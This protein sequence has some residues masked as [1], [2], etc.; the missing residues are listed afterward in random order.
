MP[1]TPLNALFLNCTLKRSPELSH[2]DALIEASRA[3]MEANGVSVDA[4][5]PVA[6]IGYLLIVPGLLLVS[7]FRLYLKDPLAQLV[8]AVG[9]SLI[10]VMVLG[11]VLSG[12]PASIIEQPL[13]AEVFVPVSLAITGGLALLFILAL[14]ILGTAQQEAS[15]IH[16]LA[17]PRTIG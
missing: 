12:I 1:D 2:T 11:L 7:I 16:Q 10:Y 13:S 5:R 14:V 9:L 8:T 17:G 3:I 6:A 4:L 15:A